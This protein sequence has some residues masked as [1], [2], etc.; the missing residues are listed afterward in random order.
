M[1]RRQLFAL[2]P[3]CSLAAQSKPTLQPARRANWEVFW[4]PE[5]VEWKRNNG[6]RYSVEI[7]DSA[8][9]LVISRPRFTPTVLTMFDPPASRL[10]YAANATPAPQITSGYVWLYGF[11]NTV[12]IVWSLA[13]RVNVR[14]SGGGWATGHLPPPPNS[15]N[16]SVKNNRFVK[17]GPMFPPVMM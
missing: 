6:E 2:A 9:S 10:V 12:N 4:S 8:R 17:I 11:P 5:F 16:V 13:L 7:A 1:T 14:R 15:I 3:A